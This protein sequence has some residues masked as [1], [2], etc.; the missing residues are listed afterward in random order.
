MEA[1]VKQQAI[2]TQDL[3]TTVNGETWVSEA[4]VSDIEK[5]SNTSL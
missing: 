3:S 4:V 1:R 5:V 2:V